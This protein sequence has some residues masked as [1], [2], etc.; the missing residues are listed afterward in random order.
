MQVKVKNCCELKWYVSQNMELVGVL[1]KFVFS[2]ALLYLCN[3]EIAWGIKSFSRKWQGL[4]SLGSKMFYTRGKQRLI[5]IKFWYASEASWTSLI[6]NSIGNYLFHSLQRLRALN[7]IV[8]RFQT[9][10]RLIYSVF[11]QTFIKCTWSLI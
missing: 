4:F 1:A 8:C 2:Q 6:L 10:N 11:S 3:W 5:M 7:F 9:N